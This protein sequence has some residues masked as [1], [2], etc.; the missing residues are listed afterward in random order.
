MLASIL[1]PWMHDGG[2]DH[3]LERLKDPQI[4]LRV[5]EEMEQGI[6]GWENFVEF[7]GW[8]GIVIAFCEKGKELEGKSILQI[9]NERDQE[10]AE[11][12]FD[13]LLE[14]AGKVVMVVYATATMGTFMQSVL[15]IL[16][17]R[18]MEDVRLK[19]QA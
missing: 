14:E 8:E 2:I 17:T 10:P 4:R 6:K 3:A 19:T 9:A 15:N 1:P 12:A 16:L 18:E 7:V 13:I 5:K 11:T